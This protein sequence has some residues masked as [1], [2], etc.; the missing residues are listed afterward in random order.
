MPNHDDIGFIKG[1]RDLDEE[2][3]TELKN[4]TSAR[5]HV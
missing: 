4:A 2:A 5:L 1:A 3:G